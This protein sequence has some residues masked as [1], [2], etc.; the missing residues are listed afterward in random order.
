MNRKLTATLTALVLGCS[1]GAILGGCGSSETKTVTVASSPAETPSTQA[2]TATTPSTTTA[3]TTTATT[4]TAGGTPAPTNTRTQTAPAFTHEETKSEGLSEAES[5]LQAKGYS[6][7][8]TSQYH[9]NQALRVLI[10]T[11]SGSDDGYG[12]QAFFFVNGRYIG[13]DTKEPSATV[14]V[15]S[16]NDTEVTLAYPLYRPSD[17]LASPNGG[18]ATVHF[19]LND[20]KLTPLGTIPPANSSTGLSRN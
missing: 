18:Q 2:N 17:P 19:Q 16:Q 14:K 3:T 10:G 20:G 7:A 1:A 6:A 12:Q 15:L 4:N 8:E 9:P 5:V 13:T 11:K